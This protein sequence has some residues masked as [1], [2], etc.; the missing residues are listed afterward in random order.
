MESNL[1]LLMRFPNQ[2]C[3]QPHCQSPVHMQCRAR[4]NEVPP[5]A[6]P[7]ATVKTHRGELSC[8]RAI[9]SQADS[10]LAPQALKDFSGCSH[11]EH[12]PSCCYPQ[13]GHP[14]ASSHRAA[15]LTAGGR[16]GGCGQDWVP[17]PGVEGEGDRQVTGTCGATQPSSPA[18]DWHTVGGLVPKDRSC[19]SR[20][21]GCWCWSTLH[22][23]ALGQLLPINDAT[24]SSPSK[25]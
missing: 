8:S 7:Q 18:K 1:G 16:W 20:P 21:L 24:T 25:S 4:F 22:R 14:E 9:L 3:F 19:H 6:F 13:P 11:P 23:P 2:G 17:L 15:S 10:R 12:H 5:W